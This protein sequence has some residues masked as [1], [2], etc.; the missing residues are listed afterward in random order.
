MTWTSVQENEKEVH[1]RDNQLFWVLVVVRLTTSGDGRLG[2]GDETAA[3][4]T[5]GGRGTTTSEKRVF[6]KLKMEQQMV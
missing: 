3:K 4:A 1:T 5:W 6:S 2:E